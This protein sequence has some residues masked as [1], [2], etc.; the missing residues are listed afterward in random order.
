MSTEFSLEKF[1]SEKIAK[2]DKYIANL[3]GD[4]QEELIHVL[5]YSQRLFTFLPKEIQLYVAKSLDLPAAKVFGVA[6]FYSYF[7]LN[8]VG[9]YTINICM[10]TA[11][12]VRSAEKV[13]DEFKTAKERTE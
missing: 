11:C 10:G 5:H 3:E 13:L 12:F 2:L 7:N 9:K 8:P 1:D 6:S 4:L